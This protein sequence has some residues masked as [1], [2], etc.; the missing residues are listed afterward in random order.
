MLLARA[1]RSSTGRRAASYLAFHAG[2]AVRRGGI[3]LARKVLNRSIRARRGRPVPRRGSKRRGA[4]MMPGIG[5][6]RQVFNFKVCH[7][8]N[9]VGD[10]SVITDEAVIALNDPT[11][12]MVVPAGTVQPTGWEE[13]AAF[14]D[15]AKVISVSVHCRF[16]KTS[17]DI[18][19]LAVGL[20]ANTDAT[21]SHTAIIWTNWCEFPRAQIR[22]ISGMS[23][24][25]TIRNPVISMNYHTKPWKHYNQTFKN[26]R[27]E[28]GLPDTSPTDRVFLHL[29]MG[30]ADQATVA[31]T[32]SCIVSLTVRW[33][34]L[35]YDRKN[36]TKSSDA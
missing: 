19:G 36:L 32:S 26:Q 8:L 13:R 24:A 30:T 18:K 31:A 14:Y 28:I 12:F 10:A 4:S 5:L 3:S 6:K 25:G 34:V 35:F 29:F 9:L 33:K 27:F 15:K 7:T 21:A 2:R 20:L 16:E 23:A 17:T 22:H 11:D 1:A